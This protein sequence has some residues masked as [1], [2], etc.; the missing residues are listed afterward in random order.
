VGLGLA[1]VRAIIRGHKGKL[2]LT[3]RPGHTEFRIRLKRRSSRSSTSPK[4]RPT[5]PQKN[6]RCLEDYLRRAV[7]E[8]TI[9]VRDPRAAALAFLATLHS[10]V[11]LQHVMNVLEE[12]LPLSKYLDT[13]IE[14][15]TG[16]VIVTKRTRG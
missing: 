5:P 14:V 16:G 7:R 12:P 10:Y 13:V 8:K 9:R 15:W 3:S 2:I 11:F 6:L 4:S 1:F